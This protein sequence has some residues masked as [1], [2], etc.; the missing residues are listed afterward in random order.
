MGVRTGLTPGL[1]QRAHGAA[2]TA[3][4]QHRIPHLREAKLLE[5]LRVGGGEFGDAEGA[6]G[7][8]G[9]VVV[10]AAAGEAGLGGSA[11]SS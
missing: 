2:F 5:V 1:E 9:A 8:C 3:S 6:E 7:E 4:T 10:D 11:D